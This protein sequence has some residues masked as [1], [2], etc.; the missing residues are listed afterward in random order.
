MP[1]RRKNST[2]EVKV[3]PTPVQEQLL[4]DAVC[5]LL[6]DQAAGMR[7][8]ST[9]LGRGQAAAAIASACPAAQVTCHFLDS[10]LAG[11]AREFAGASLNFETEC[12]AEFPE[13]PI[14][15]A[16]IPTH[17]GVEPELTRDRLQSTHQA[18]VEGG[19][20]AVSTN[21][22]KDSWLHEL[23][24]SMFDK[25]TRIA[26]KKR[27]V[28]Y[29][30][31]KTGPLKKLK[32]FECRFTF[33]DHD[34]LITLVS[35]PG[36]FCHR[37]LDDGARALLK[38]VEVRDSD[39][40]IDMG[41]G[42]GAVGLALAGRN[43]KI[44]VT[45]VDSNARAVWCAEQGAVANELANFQAVHT[46][47]G[48]CEGEGSYDLFLGNPPYFSNYRIAELFLQTAV[49]MLKPGGEIMIVSKSIS[50][51]KQRMAELFD[52][53]GFAESGHYNIVG[54]VNRRRQE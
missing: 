16:V 11:L 49:R 17:S 10:Y 34:R 38:V 35:R 13:A 37:R 40:I 14:D 41:C 36:V 27:G 22:P 44:T 12:S 18:L 26:T 33:P 46:A 42:A 19:R 4:I 28:V 6:E 47:D 3:P 30:A 5:P 32:S 2:T 7:V 48:S 8:L 20:F 29:I 15:L 51:Y 23:M 54:G 25:V 45:G 31:R 1:R 53:V 43:A 9:T 39:R 50:W 52:E 24:Q 21:D